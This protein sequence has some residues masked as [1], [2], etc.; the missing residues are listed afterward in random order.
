MQ[1]YHFTCK[2]CGYETK[3]PLGSSDFDQILTDT[4]ADYAEYRLFICKKEAKFVHAD[5]HNRD[6]ECRCPSDG[7]ELMEI[8]ELPSD[9]CPRCNQGNLVTEETGPLDEINNTS[10]LLTNQLIYY[11]RRQITLLGSFRLPDALKK[12]EHIWMIDAWNRKL[13]F[14]HWV[15][16]PS[17]GGLV[18]KLKSSKP[19]WLNVER[20]QTTKLHGLERQD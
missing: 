11:G 12:G 1:I 8:S 14:S 18:C 2:S 16:D 10:T 17:L 5:I 19:L 6:F 9:K 13:S 7:S 20:R 15:L 4:N 3:L